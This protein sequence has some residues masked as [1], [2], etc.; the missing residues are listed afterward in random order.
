MV[1]VLVVVVAMVAVAMTV[2]IIVVELTI[3]HRRNLARYHVCCKLFI[4]SNSTNSV[5]GEV[6]TRTRGARSETKGGGKGNR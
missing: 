5:S 3:A 6:S 4:R 2:V 1:V